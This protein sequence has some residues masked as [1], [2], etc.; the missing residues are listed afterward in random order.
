MLLAA[1]L[2]ERAWRVRLA[3][4]RAC[5]CC[6]R[7]RLR[8]ARRRCVRCGSRGAVHACGAQRECGVWR[9]RARACRVQRGGGSA[10]LST[11][12]KEAKRCCA[13]GARAVDPPVPVRV[14][15]LMSPQAVVY[16]IY[17]CLLLT[18]ELAG[19]GTNRIIH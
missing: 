8:L 3:V 1:V 18:P 2:G 9:L 14:L 7:A 15:L 4:R 17:F 13:G 12:G 6:C 16:R 5:A 11:V 10:C 19:A